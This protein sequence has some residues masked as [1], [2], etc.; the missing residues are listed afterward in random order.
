MG[1]IFSHGY[2]SLT[3]YVYTKIIS[4]KNRKRFK[5]TFFC[6]SIFFILKKQTFERFFDRKTT[7]STPESC[8]KCQRHSVPIGPPGSGREGDRTASLSTSHPLHPQ[9][10]QALGQTWFRLLRVGLYFPPAGGTA[11]FF[12]PKNPVKTKQKRYIY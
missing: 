5:S 1:L 2:K 3:K 8:S 7:T 10:R 4:R 11:S 6:F 12:L 9:E